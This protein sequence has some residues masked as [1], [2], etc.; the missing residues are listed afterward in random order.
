[1]FRVLDNCAESQHLLTY[2]FHIHHYK[3]Q[4]QILEWLIYKKLTG[5][6][7]MHFIKEKNMSPMMLVKW[8]MM[9]AGRKNEAPAIFYGKDIL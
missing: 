2:L 9:E 3:Q 8:V 4:D 6:R 7:L 1:M 5:I